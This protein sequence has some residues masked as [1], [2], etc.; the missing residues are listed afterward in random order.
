MAKRSKQSPPVVLIAAVVREWSD[1][2]GWGVLD[3][4]ETPG[5][6]WTHFSHIRSEGYRSLTAGQRVWIGVEHAV[7]QDG[8]RWRATQVQL[9]EDPEQHLAEDAP[10]SHH[11]AYRS[12]LT[13]AL[14]DGTVVS[15]A[16]AMALVEQMGRDPDDPSWT[17]YSPLTDPR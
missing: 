15:G 14:E 7:D 2:Q 10:S 9:S 17:T 16:E 3:S 13:L 4:P 11:G 1:E 12:C 5:G 6:C 8:F